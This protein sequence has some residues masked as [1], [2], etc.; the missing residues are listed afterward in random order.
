MALFDILLQQ[1]GKI[2]CIVFNFKT[3]AERT[4]RINII[5]IWI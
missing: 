2:Y 3:L 1:P 5:I 4:A